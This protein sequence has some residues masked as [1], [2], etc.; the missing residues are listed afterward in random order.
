MRN[1]LSSLRKSFVDAFRTN[2]YLAGWAKRHERTFRFL[3][4]RLSRSEFNGFIISVGVV[5]GALF[6]FF[7]LSIA[8][9]VVTNAPFVQADESI[10]NLIY[11]LRSL[12]FAQ[13]MLVFTHLGSLAVVLCFSLIAIVLWLLVK[14]Y[15]KIKF[16]ILSVVSGE[17]LAQALK[18]LIHRERPSVD[19]AL[20][21]RAGYAFPSGHA[22]VSV[23][24][25]GLLGYFVM[26]H[27]RRRRHKVLVALATLALIFFI[28]FSRV[29]IGA[30]WTT[31]VLAGW[32][33]G[34]AVLAVVVAFYEQR[35]RFLPVF[36]VKSTSLRTT[37]LAVAASLLVWGGLFVY[38]YTTMNPLVAR[39]QLS[40]QPVV[41]LASLTNLE[42]AIPGDQFPKYSQGISG[43]KMESVSLVVVGTRAQLAQA[44]AAAGWL[45]ADEPRFR[46]WDDLAFAAILNRPYPTAPVTPAFIHTQPNDVAFEKPTPANTV[47]QRHHARF[48]QTNFSVSGRPVW[49]GTASFDDGIRYLVTHRIR[50]DVDTE[51]DFIDQEL[52][53]TGYVAQRHE[54]QLVPRF[55]GQNQ[56]SDVFFTDG[57][58]YLMVLK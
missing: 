22:T 46:T 28:G 30:H 15:R 51:R 45:T 9:D 54:L 1:F 47:R 35:N 8:Y 39:P 48:W 3:K 33:L 26:R 58:A 6:L 42:S 53:A 19:L 57:R 14:D 56:G 17:V 20:V 5:L 44:F 40:A 12:R 41:E 29:Y 31:D 52:A 13:V 24:F 27:M 55:L 2:E 11:M 37:R 43:K 34:L 38:Y 25:Y 4:R 18:V 16:F 10:M 49:V 36:R 21:P 50:P 32:L 7:C 23:V